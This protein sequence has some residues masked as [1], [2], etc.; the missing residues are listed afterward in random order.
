APTSTMTGGGYVLPGVH[1][2]GVRPRLLVAAVRRSGVAG[3]E[4]IGGAGLRPRGIASPTG[5]T[6]AG[7]PLFRAAG[8]APPQ[9]WVGRLQR[10]ARLRTP[11]ICQIRTMTI[12]SRTS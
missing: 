6:L 10:G 8:P 1:R 2:A 7:P 3:Q 12:R 9:F 5:E 4:P 11:A